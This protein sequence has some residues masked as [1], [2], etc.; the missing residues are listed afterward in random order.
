ME[1]GRRRGR[2]GEGILEERKR[3]EGNF[4]FQH[5]FTFLI[6]VI[7]IRCLK[8]LETHPIMD[9]EAIAK[10]GVTTAYLQ[11]QEMKSRWKMQQELRNY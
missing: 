6:T 1:A 2:G 7:H 5:F 9:K 8:E 10:G 11:Q 4:H 3:E